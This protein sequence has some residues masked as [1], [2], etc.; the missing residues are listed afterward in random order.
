MKLIKLFSILILLMELSAE[1]V[2][3]HREFIANGIVYDFEVANGKIYS[4]TGFGEIDIFS[5]EN[6]DIID[7]V[8]FSELEDFYGDKIKRKIYSVSIFKE[9]ILSLVEAE[10]GKKELY[11]TENGYTKRVLSTSS[12]IKKAKLINEK[13]LIYATLGN[14]FVLFDYQNLKEIYKKQISSSSFSDFDIF[15]DEV[16]ISSESGEIFILDILTGN[17]KRVFSG[18]NVDNVYKVSFG[19][20]VVLGAGQDRRLSIYFKN[21]SYHIPAEF[22]IYAVALSK[23]EKIGAFPYNLENYISIFDVQSGKKLQDLR[24]Q[25]ST[26]NKIMFLEENR[27]LSSS[28]DKYILEWRF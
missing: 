7:K 6:G 25:K 26:L 4:A 24:G 10:Y 27:V 23:S 1:I 18:E 9:N 17:K 16:A 21:S 8:I 11:L 19:K 2:K 12:P 20:N 22:L 3:P 14:E 5:L 28:D 15:G 13:Y